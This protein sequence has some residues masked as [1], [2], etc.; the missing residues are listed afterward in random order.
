MSELRSLA[1]GG[2]AILAAA[3][4]TR[5][6]D[7]KGR[8]TYAGKHLSLASFRESSELE[9]GMRF[10]VPAVP[11]RRGRGGEPVRSVTLAH[12][13]NRDGE[14]KDTALAFDRRVQKFEP[15]PFLTAASPSAEADRVREVWGKAARNGK[16]G[17]PAEPG[18]RAY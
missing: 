10:G 1:D 16:R 4:L 8:S 11:D 12:E 13:K 2:A 9:Y 14:T 17:S 5:S 6:R 3:A 15:D 7:S 18:E